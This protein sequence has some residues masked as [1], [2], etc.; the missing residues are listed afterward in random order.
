MSTADPAPS[1]V[2]VSRDLPGEALATLAEQHDVRV[3]PGDEPPS[4][5]ELLAAVAHADALICTLNDRIDEQVFAA[6]PR[7]RAVSNYAV[8]FENIDVARAAE[9]GIPVGNTPD[10]LTDAT[11]QF[12][13]ALTIDLLRR[14]SES[15]A[16]VRDGEWRTWAPTGFLGRDFQDTTVGVIGWGRI[17]RAYAAL[18]AAVGMRV[19]HTGDG[20]TVEEVL[21][22]SDVVS[23]H[24]PLTTQ[25]HHLIDSAALGRMRPGSHLVNTARGGVV[26][27]DALVAAL[28]SGRLAGAGLDVTDPEPLPADHP[29][30]LDA[31]VI[32]TPHIASASLRSRAGMADRA[33]A[34]VA[35]ALRGE[36]MPHCVNPEVYEAHRKVG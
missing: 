26:D 25:T 8:G 9:R 33:A 14:V 29:L 34:N 32:V 22:R 18:A 20:V 7:L 16:T 28:A 27:T 15:A 2:F 21:E 13:F 5:S 10:A 12:A 4:R 1:L 24:V 3:W 6:A 31:R 19:I 36:R 23:L 35:A 30:V 17:G 11:A